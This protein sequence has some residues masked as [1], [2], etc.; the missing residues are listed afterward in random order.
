M[1]SCLLLVVFSL[2]SIFSKF[3]PEIPFRSCRHCNYDTKHTIWRMHVQRQDD[4]GEEN[5]KDDIQN[6]ITLSNSGVS[7]NHLNRLS[8]ERSLSGNPYKTSF[9]MNTSFKT[10]YIGGLFELS[11]IRGSNGLSELIAAKLAVEHVN[12]K[13][14][15][16]G[17]RMR[18]LFNNT[19]VSL[20]IYRKGVP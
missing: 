11:G 17:Y 18:L 2:N 9:E 15:V 6:N 16:P 4:N 7:Y 3:L 5:V 19:K 20:I 13:N 12:N 10:I 8:H 1:L 14:A